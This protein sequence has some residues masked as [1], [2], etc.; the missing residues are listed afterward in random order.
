MIILLAALAMQQDSSLLAVVGTQGRAFATA[1]APAAAAARGP[2]AQQY[3]AALALLD[4]GKWD[5]AAVRLHAVSRLDA[6][7]PAV[8]GDL[9]YAEARRGQWDNAADAYQAA[10]GMQPDNPWYYVGLG[11]ARGEQSR[12]IE[13]AGMF[14]LAAHTDSSVISPAFITGITDY[15]DHAGRT[16]NQLDWYKIATARYPNESLWWL[17]LAQSLRDADDTTNGLAAARHYVAMR[18]SE[19]LGMATLAAFLAD[20][21]KS[22]SAV[23]IAGRLAG[24][25]TSYRAFAMGIFWTAGT[26]AFR[27]HDYAKAAQVL[28][29]GM[30]YARPDMLP[31]FAYYAGH[32]DLQRAV[33]LGQASSES[34]DCNAA[35]ASDSLAFLADTNLR[36]AMSVDS[37][38]V[39]QVVGTTIPQ[40]HQQVARL[41]AAYCQA[42]QQQQQQ[43]RRP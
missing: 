26:H 16:S 28:K 13:A 32:A 14:S 43:R 41:K 15:Y 1:H 23:E 25:D 39:S 7:N 40:V 36:R 17:K 12:F 21:G 30:Q 24:A 38:T 3:R 8:K 27:A 29:Q 2:T 42:A 6:R 33:A 10:S 37:G 4:S 11:I 9:G 22:D 31:R 19:P 34:R 35:L 5:D 18:P 20:V